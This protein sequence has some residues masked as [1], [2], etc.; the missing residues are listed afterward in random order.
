MDRA[1]ILAALRRLASA[2]AARG[3]AGDLF[4][5]GGSAIAVAYDGRRA[6]RDIDAVFAPKREIYESAAQVA[7]ELGLPDDWLN[8]AV[9]GF[10]P[11]SVARPGTPDPDAVPV[12]DEPG[13]RV[14]AASP[15]YL[16]AMKL[17]ASRREDEDDLRWLCKHL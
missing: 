5:V 16:L 3:V 15:R 1:E 11:T 10:L 17:M 13:L 6:T 12:F 2:L 7:F 4:V 8:D 9:K 14:M